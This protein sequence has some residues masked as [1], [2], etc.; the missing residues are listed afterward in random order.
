MRAI[1]L[2][3]PEYETLRGSAGIIDRS[4][5]GVVRLDGPDRRSFLQGLLTNDIQALT[6][7]SSCYAALLTPQGRMIADMHVLETGDCLLLDVRR[8]QAAALVERLDGSIFTEDVSVRDASSEYQRLALG[9]P[10]AKR[11]LEQALAI[12]PRASSRQFADPAWEVPMFELIV[13]SPGV[14][15]LLAALHA[16]GGVDVGPDALDAVRIE[17]GIPLFGTDMDEETIPLEAGIEDRAISFTKGCYVGQEVI[18]RVLHRGHGRVAKKL[19]PLTIDVSS[20][21]ALPTPGTSIGKQDKEIG[22]LTS[23]AWSPR[24]GKGVAL[25]YVHRDFADTP[26]ELSTQDGS[27]MH[28]LKAFRDKEPPGSER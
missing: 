17:S 26:D 4:D 21:E 1:V 9:G 14:A 7:G 15:D 3:I 19:V 28:V 12:D 25:G 11:V 10:D 13:E 16:A 6:P 24:L 22:R 18:I 23:V 27:T 5:R 8:D 2:R 20:E